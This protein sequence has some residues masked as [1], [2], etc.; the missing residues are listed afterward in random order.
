LEGPRSPPD[1][2]GVYL[3]PE[4][5]VDPLARA[6][7]ARGIRCVRLDLLDCA[8]KAGFLDRISGAL[9][10]PA[11]VGRN[12]DA[13]ADAMGELRAACTPGLLLLV[14]NGARMQRDCGSEFQTAMDV[15]GASSAEWAG[16]GSPLWVF[17][18]VP[19]GH[20]QADTGP[21]A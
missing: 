17:I 7:A 10:L 16:R 4:R 3:V 9:G 2:P 12:W 11:R 1:E 19:A 21:G 8:T 5:E 15:L 13:L 18:A 14:L 6:A 20:G